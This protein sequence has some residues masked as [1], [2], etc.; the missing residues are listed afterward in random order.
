MMQT[1]LFQAHQI[2]LVNHVV[3]QNENGDAAYLKALELAKEIKTQVYKSCACIGG[4]PIERF[5]ST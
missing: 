2:G 4:D 5:V 3:T 1:V